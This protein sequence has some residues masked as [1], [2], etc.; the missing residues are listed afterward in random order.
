MTRSAVLALT[1]VTGFTGLSYEVTW[2]K[3]LA[4]LLGAHSEATASVLGLFLGGLSLGYWLFGALTR[5]LVR[6]GAERGEPPRLLVVYGGVEASIG[7]YCLL[8]PAVFPLIHGVSVLL[9]TGAG[10]L[11]FAVDVALAAI[12]VLPP[13]VLMGGTIPLLT[14]ALARDLPDATRIHAFIYAFNTAG[15]FLGA[16]AAGF[17]LIHWLGLPGVMMTMGAINIA[18]GAILVALGWRRRDLADL[19]AG[20]P[21][22][23]PSRLPWL[24]GFVALLIG[25]AMM[26]FQTI[27]IRLGG[28]SFGSSEYTFSMV[29][30]VF[31]LCIALG[32]AA[33]SALPRVGRSLLPVAI[34]LLAA[35]FA[36][37]YFALETGP[38]WAHLLRT[39]FRDDIATFYPYCLAVFFG[40]LLVMG[41]PVFVSGAM[42]P[43]LFHEL[44]REMGDLGSRAGR[45][46]SLNTVGSLLGALLGGYALLFWLDLHHVYRIGVAALLLAAAILTA[47]QFRRL[48]AVAVAGLFLA[49]LAGLASFHAWDP[50]YLASGTFR[51]RDVRFWTYGGPSAMPHHDFHY[52]FYDDDPN[53]SVAVL[54]WGEE[55]D[56][57]YSESILVN[58]KPDGNSVGDYR[59]MAMAGLLPA[60]LAEKAESAFVIG[61]GTG[62]T[63]GVLAHLEEVEHVTVAEISPAVVEAAPYFDYVSHGASTHPEIEVVKS[64]AYRA[65]LK[66]D[67]SYDVIVSE[68]SNPWVTGV[69][70][71]FSREFL[72]EAR[73]RLSDRG[74]YCQWFHMYETSDEAIELVLRTYSAV[75]DHVAVWSE[76]GVDLLLLG[77]KDPAHALDLA[78]LRE[79]MF[80][81]DFAEGLGLLGMKGPA[82]LL[83]HETLPLGVVNAARL[84]GP[85]HSLYAPLLS[86]EAGRGFYVGHEGS[87]PFLGYGEAARIGFARSLLRRHLLSFPGE[88]IPEN[89]VE[90]T[91]R[92]ACEAGLRS[93]ETLLARWLPSPEALRGGDTWANRL[94]YAEERI[95]LARELQPFYAAPGANR[96]GPELEPLDVLNTTQQ[97]LSRYVHAAPFQLR[98]L[99][100]MWQRCGGYPEAQASCA[101]GLGYVRGIGRGEPPPPIDDWFPGLRLAEESGL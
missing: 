89:A 1:L 23:G 58:G 49:C 16:L 63:A 80:R 52:S 76:S 35:L 4:I 32:S 24:Y 39:L 61:W 45:L 17:V 65:L 18:V 62:V 90:R 11:S 81:E 22:S 47:A 15:A 2:Q 33:V 29:V 88:D 74:V 46:Y 85:V 6:R 3:Y 84:E 13:A 87:L 34:W 5:R 41:P 83:A 78:R 30:A 95:E 42:L 97:Y 100:E 64:D 54:T 92:R 7:L 56:P 38:Y 86:Y 14:Q 96:A 36:G 72:E 59:T 9:P 25:F 40:L 99:V 51:A 82:A 19:D 12:L 101:Q 53:S 43:L 77:F 31:V 60:L 73:D 69:E 26:V 98:G 28:L 27:L 55:G 48:P 94:P 67:R 79:R 70:M 37:L 91:V 21:P 50:A 57:D 93:C 20:P 10:P 68:P 71:L 44:K 66:S 8:F 75:F